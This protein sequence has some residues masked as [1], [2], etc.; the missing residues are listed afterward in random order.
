MENRSPYIQYVGISPEIGVCRYAGNTQRKVTPPHVIK[1]G[2][3]QMVIT[4]IRWPIWT[5]VDVMEH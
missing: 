2:A 5:L 3:Y 4:P 1:W